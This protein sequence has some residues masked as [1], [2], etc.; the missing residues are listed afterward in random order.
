MSTKHSKYRN[1]IIGT[2]FVGSTFKKKSNKKT[3]S[4]DGII[5]SENNF[6][7]RIK[8]IHQS[9]TNIPKL[10]NKNKELNQYEEQ[11]SKNIENNTQNLNN[12]EEYFS[13]FFTNILSKK[14]I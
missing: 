3:I 1:N 14:P 9:K 11:I 5:D 6:Y 7:T 12:P 2:T 4:P 10:N 8:E 13:G